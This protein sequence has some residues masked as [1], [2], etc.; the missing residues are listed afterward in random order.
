VCLC[1]L[2]SSAALF[3]TEH[4]SFYGLAKAIVFGVHFLGTHNT[5]FLLIGLDDNV[6]GIRCRLSFNMR[7]DHFSHF[8]YLIHPLELFDCEV[9]QVCIHGFG[10]CVHIQLCVC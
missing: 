5:Q 3:H 1:S 10:V 9:Y 6:M 4:D 2:N 8:L 7:Q